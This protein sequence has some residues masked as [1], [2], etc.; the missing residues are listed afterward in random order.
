VTEF[1][2]KLRKVT[3][4]Y[5]PYQVAAGLR[6]L[7]GLVF[8]DSSGNFPE[9][10]HGAVSMIAARPLEVLRGGMDNPVELER[11]LKRYR[12]A[13]QNGLPCGGL[14]GWIDYDGAFCFGVYLEMLVYDHAAEQWW[15]VGNLSEEI[16]ADPRAPRDV[17]MGEFSS[18]MDEQEYTDK[19]RRIHE[20]IAAGDIYQVNLT[21]RFE[22]EVEGGSLFGLYES[23]RESAPAPMASWMSLDGREVLSSSPETFL[24]MHGRHIETRPIKGTRPRFADPEKDKASAEELM[25]SEKEVSELVMIT[26]LERNDIGQVCEFGSVKVDELVKLETLE[27][28]YHLVSLVSGQLRPEISQLEALNACFPGGSITGAPKIRSMEIIEELET[29]PR[30]LYTGAVGYF[31]F[32]EVSQFNIVIRTLIREAGMI[33]YH[34]GAGIVADSDPEMEYEETLQ[35][36]AGVRKAL[37]KWGR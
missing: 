12:A 8:F 10:Y 25:A 14:C 16:D 28:V 19:V 13:E 15:Q 32:N 22:A 18:N 27:H 17:T 11:R 6:H 26:D 36:A 24:R 7:E 33:R 37:D 21:Q 9:N 3:L 31:G 5:T 35:K 30:G 2:G 20:Y 1:E 29:V 4:P 23:L 34:V